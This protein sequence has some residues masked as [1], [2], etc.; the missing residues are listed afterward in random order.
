MKEL[1]E[2]LT[3][4]LRKEGLENAVL[5]NKALSI[6]RDVVGEAIADRATPEEIKHGTLVVRAETPVWRNELVFRKGE[7]LQKLNNALGKQVIR[8][9][10]LV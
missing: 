6:W 4:L 10:K 5:Q 3:A 2:I 1:R 8:D 9:I 7:I